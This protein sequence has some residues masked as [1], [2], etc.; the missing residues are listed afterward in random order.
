MSDTTVTPANHRFDAWLI[1]A[2][3]L[4]QGAAIAVLVHDSINLSLSSSP[5]LQS[6]LWGWTLLLPPTAQW[7]IAYR[8]RHSYWLLLGFVALAI[9]AIC[10]EP[11]R[12]ILPEMN[13]S[14]QDFLASGGMLAWAAVMS[15]ASAALQSGGIADYPSLFRL[16]CRTILLPLGAQ[17]FSLFFWLLL[18][19]CAALFELLGID[20][21]Q[22]L[23]RGWFLWPV[24]GVAYGIAT[25]ILIDRPALVDGVRRVGTAI[26]AALLPVAVIIHLLF[27][28][29]IAVVGLE[30]LWATRHAT[31]LVLTL[32]GIFLLLLNG[33]H[34]EGT[35]LDCL[36]RP[37]AGVVRLAL[38][39]SP[40]YVAIAAYSLWLRVAQYGWSPDRMIG[41]CV[42]AFIG[43]V[44]L[45]YI[46]AAARKPFF[47][48]PRL[49][50]ANVGA[51]AGLA[52]IG[53][54]VN[55]PLLS[56]K[57]IAAA[58]QEQ[59]ILTGRT[60]PETIDWRQLGFELGSYGRSVV[61][62]LASVTDIPRAAEI[63][64]RADD[65][66]AT[67]AERR[68]GLMQG[69]APRIETPK[70]S[71][72]PGNSEPPPGLVDIVRARFVGSPSSSSCAK[73]GV[74]KLLAIDLNGDGQPEMILLDGNLPVY[75]QQNGRWM[76]F[77]VLAGLGTPPMSVD[78]IDAVTARL[79][80]GRGRSVAGEWQDVEVD[81]RRLRIR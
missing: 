37:M 12:S 54:A 27:L 17:L 49:A 56:P 76:Y 41:A 68:Y 2:L 42:T 81:G 33:T 60:A 30:P 13:S 65:T 48:L 47:I 40:I 59:R 57:R 43:L 8:G 36:P 55:S 63:R 9:P 45:A 20:L 21:F 24:L 35:K 3:G 16:T 15:L 69:P 74:C 46:V 5:W 58:S 80:E 38:V 32:L 23:F 14:Q 75:R 10:W 7:L 64:Q 66:L 79:A 72:V 73:S 31:P 29:G 44:L 62:R 67:P 25:A 78:E 50:V 61:H 19:L 53:I 51:L 70:F 1:I 4:L 71:V 77:G 34:E 11:A 52:I 39:L 28:G 6:S 18:T 26:A 22:R